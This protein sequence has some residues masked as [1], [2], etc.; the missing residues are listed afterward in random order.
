MLSL[1]ELA[2]KAVGSAKAASAALAGYRGI[3]RT[4][5]REHG[6]LSVLLLRIATDRD[7]SARA[8]L[9][10]TVARELLAHGQ[11]EDAE[12]YPI[13][14]EH[15]S[16]RDLVVQLEADHERIEMLLAELLA[17]PNAGSAWL[18]RF[19]ELQRAVQEH[20]EQEE[21][22]VFPRARRVLSPE[23]IEEIDRRYRQARARGARPPVEI[24]DFIPPI[25]PPDLH[26]G[27]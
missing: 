2:S 10:P 17:A 25:D 24:D 13:L 15:E 26:P 20:V 11:A 19:R 3:F 23:L 1:T 21:N 4:L 5:K 18:V 6:E 22:L 14:A 9:F 27:L 7:G 12:L 16:T 8:E